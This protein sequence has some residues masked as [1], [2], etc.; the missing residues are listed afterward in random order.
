[1]MALN[2]KLLR[3]LQHKSYKFS[4]LRDLYHNF[5]TL[6]I[7]ELHI[8]QLLILVHKFLHHK[9]L[10][11]TAFANYFKINSA[12]HLH[13]TRVRENLHLESLSTNYGKRIVRYKASKIW[14]KLP[15]SLKV[16]EGDMGWGRGPP[17]FIL[18]IGYF[19][20]IREITLKYDYITHRIATL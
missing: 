6:A 2:N 10:L 1:M 12:I 9:Q 7:P 14:N 17:V 11:P 19:L 20:Y 16:G 8:H 13:N 4:D 3:I 18:Q 5:D 15:S